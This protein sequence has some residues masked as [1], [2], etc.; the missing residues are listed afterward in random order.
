MKSSLNLRVN[1]IQFEDRK[2]PCL[3]ST[4]LNLTNINEIVSATPLITYYA[5]IYL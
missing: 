5:Q 2:I 1:Q 3:L 4:N